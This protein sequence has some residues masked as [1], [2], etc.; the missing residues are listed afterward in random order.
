MRVCTVYRTNQKKS[1]LVLLIYVK[2]P[3]L[4]FYYSL[5]VLVTCVYSLCVCIFLAKYLFI[6]IDRTDFS[7]KFFFSLCQFKCNNIKWTKRQTKLTHKNVAI[8]CRQVYSQF[9]ELYSKKKDIN[10]VSMWR[11]KERQRLNE[12]IEQTQNVNV[13]VARLLFDF[14]VEYVK[15]CNT[16][17]RR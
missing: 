7:S 16:Y 14:H 2:S 4:T 1:A 11:V 15:I 13:N 12:E 8:H 6:P 10:N 3:P 5:F 9:V 17:T